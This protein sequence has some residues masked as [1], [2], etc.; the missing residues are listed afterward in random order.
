MVLFRRFETASDVAYKERKIRGFLH[1]YNGQESVC[2]GME[3]QLTREDMI[4]TAYRDHA[5]QLSRGGTPESTM[6]ELMGKE[7]GCSKGKGGS[8]HMYHAKNH[9]YGGNGIVGAQV[10][11]GAGLAFALK[12]QNKKMLQ[13]LY[14]EM[15]L[16]IKVKYMKLLIWPLY[17]N[18]L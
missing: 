9:F 6:E 8:M 12:Y 13:L 17:G 4:I 7:G 16:L 10:P 14:M 15:E 3:S 2:A 5:Y 1:L 11:I 18:C